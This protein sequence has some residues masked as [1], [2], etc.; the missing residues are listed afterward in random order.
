MIPQHLPAQFLS[1][2]IVTRSV[3]HFSI[4]WHLL[5]DIG[6]ANAH[7]YTILH[8]AKMA[9][10]KLWKT[11]VFYLGYVVISQSFSKHAVFDIPHAACPSWSSFWGMSDVSVMNHRIIHHDMGH[12]CQISLALAPSSSSSSSSPS[13]SKTSSSLVMSS[14]FFHYSIW[15]FFDFRIPEN[16]GPS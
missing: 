9:Q 2:L 16:T 8:G 7:M 14:L 13:P 3:V 15:W 11:H 12:E 4:Q 10:T 5:G 6:A 1:S